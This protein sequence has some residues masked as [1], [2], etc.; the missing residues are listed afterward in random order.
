[1]LEAIGIGRQEKGHRLLD[2][3]SFSIG[4]GQRLA[5]VGPSGSGKTLLLRA[6][7]MLD[8]LDVGWIRWRGRA[9][10]EN[11]VPKFRGQVMFLPQRPMLPEGTV[12]EILRQ[13][14]SLK[15]H[16]GKRFDQ[17]KI[18]AFLASL[19]QSDTFLSR[20]Q[21]ELSGGQTQ[22]VALLRAIQLEPEILLLDEPT[23]ALDREAVEMAESLVTTW[24]KG[25][26]ETLRATVWVTH[27]QEQIRRVSTSS[28]H[29]RGG[30]LVEDC[31]PREARDG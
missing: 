21:G 1:M 20:R 12:E 4:F 7:A 22:L 25:Q 8:P 17:G 15:V 27:D 19:N 5:L 2:D 18:I 28:L 6:L 10:S 11:E 14:F 3:I 24:F 13:P 16:A 29:I 9:V 30:K 26:P 23:T 31:L